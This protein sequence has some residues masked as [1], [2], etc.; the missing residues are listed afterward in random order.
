M[1]LMIFQGSWNRR[2]DGLRSHI[3]KPV[4]F[5]GTVRCFSY[6]T[7]AWE[8]LRS[9]FFLHFLFLPHATCIYR[10]NGMLYRNAKRKQVPHGKYLL[11][12]CII[13]H[14]HFLPVGQ[15]PRPRTF[16]DREV[17][18]P[19]AASGNRPEAKTRSTLQRGFF[20]SRNSHELQFFFSD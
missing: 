4:F 1:I 16:P 9:L 15:W 10:A 18:I 14:R 12:I 17:Q 8:A 20:L 19:Q 3:T 2:L 13:W 11:T 5:D 6:G 7:G